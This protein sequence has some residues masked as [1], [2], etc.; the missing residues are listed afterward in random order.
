[1]LAAAST[2]AQVIMRFLEFRVVTV[3]ADRPAGL[4]C[5]CGCSL[6]GEGACALV[7]VCTGKEGGWSGGVGPSAFI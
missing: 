2:F 3:S 7:V 5:A 1:M 6:N 4:L